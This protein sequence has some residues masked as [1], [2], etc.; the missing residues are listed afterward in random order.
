M[1]RAEISPLAILGVVFLAL[2]AL[3]IGRMTAG[4]RNLAEEPDLGALPQ[5]V[6]QALDRARQVY[7]EPL[8]GARWSEVYRMGGTG[9]PIFQLKGTNSRGNQIELEVTGAG[10]IIEVE[11]HGIPLSDVPRAVVEALKAKLPHFEPARVEAV[12]QVEK[13]QPISYGFEGRDATGRKVEVYL[14]A[15]GK[16][17]LN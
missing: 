4:P 2:A 8:S 9:H 13:A 1:R 14:S 12:Y 3:G 10:R 17:F 15:D 6:R 5:E 16:T 11:E 7:A